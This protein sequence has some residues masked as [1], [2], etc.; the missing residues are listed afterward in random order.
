MTKFWSPRRSATFTVVVCFVLVFIAS[1][2]SWYGV[3]RT[4]NDVPTD[5]IC[6]VAGYSDWDCH[7]FFLTVKFALFFLMCSILFQ[8]GAKSDAS[9]LCW[10]I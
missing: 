7:R 6:A 8:F 10:H 4:V 2:V 1:V 9:V 5:M 3:A